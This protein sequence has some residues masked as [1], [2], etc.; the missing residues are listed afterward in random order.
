MKYCLI[1]LYVFF[2]TFSD[3]AQS[4][5]VKAYIIQMNGDTIRGEAKINP[6]KELNNYNKVTFRDDSG[7]QK[8]YK[9]NKIKA[10]GFNDFHF[11]S[12]TTEGEFYFFN[13]IL[14]GEISLFKLGFEAMR[15]NKP[16]YEEAF[17]LSHASNNELI[18]VK[19]GRFKK[20]LTDWMKDHPDFIEEYGDD[21][22][23]DV[24]KAIE[25]ISHYN[26]W[27][28]EHTE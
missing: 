26:A 14:A 6:K 1:G 27:K 2:F 25:V 3:L 20:Q 5:F 19:E 13:R 23:F 11:V 12:Y 8:I 10:Y 9:P 28:A 24:E 17:F 21:K 7:I 15:M 4:T 16:I 18:D 22:K